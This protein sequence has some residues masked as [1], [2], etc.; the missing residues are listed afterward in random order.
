[1]CAQLIGQGAV[2]YFKLGP[3]MHADFV[4]TEFVEE[5]KLLGANEVRM[6][7]S[8]AEWGWPAKECAEEWLAH[9]DARIRLEADERAEVREEENLSISRKALRNSERA[10]R[11]AISAIILSISM[12]ILEVIKWY[13]SK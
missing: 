11:I 2:V 9:E 6:R 5:L 10:T 4:A 12:A 1:M 13:S 3:L 7:L 8:R